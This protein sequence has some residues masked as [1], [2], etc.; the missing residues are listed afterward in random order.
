MLE[1][2]KCLSYESLEISGSQ[3]REL[4]QCCGV[5]VNSSNEVE[6]Y[7]NVRQ[8]TVPFNVEKES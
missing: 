1:D 3:V 4:S 6:A 5:A 2:G 7:A 8:P